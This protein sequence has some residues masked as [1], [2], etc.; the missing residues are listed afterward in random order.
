MEP[1]AHVQIR[2]IVESPLHAHAGAHI[3]RD[4]VHREHGG[5]A[6]ETHDAAGFRAA[7]DF[8]GGDQA[9]EDH[10]PAKPLIHGV[11]AIHLEQHR[12]P[13]LYKAPYGPVDKVSKFTA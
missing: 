1:A 8:V 5:N 3:N 10:D 6:E 4:E 12:F 13:F 9:H 11:F 7:C 2:G